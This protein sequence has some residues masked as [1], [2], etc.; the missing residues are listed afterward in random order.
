MGDDGVSGGRALSAVGSAVGL[1]WVGVGGRRVVSL[2]GGDGD[3]RSE[4]GGEQISALTRTVS[5]VDGAGGALVFAVGN[6]S[7]A[8][9]NVVV[10][11]T[12]G[13]FEPVG[14]ARCWI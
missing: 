14:E 1:C 5:G 3:A 7:P 10:G 4:T 9:L 6:V 13:W 12:D 11:E 2:S 8:G